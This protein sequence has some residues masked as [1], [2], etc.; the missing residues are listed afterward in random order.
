[1]VEHC[2]SRARIGAWHRALKHACQAE[3]LACASCRSLERVLALRVPEASRNMRAL[4]L[5]GAGADMPPEAACAE[6]EIK[7]L[8]A[9]GPQSASES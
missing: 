5:G 1:M 2:A 3:A 6:V 8:R 7:A 4:D 9:L